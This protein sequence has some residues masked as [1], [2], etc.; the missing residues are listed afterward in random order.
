MVIEGL[1][2]KSTA[3][4]SGRRACLSGNADPR[5]GRIRVLGLWLA[6]VKKLIKV[7]RKDFLPVALITHLTTPPAIGWAAARLN[8]A[9]SAIHL[10]SGNHP[11]C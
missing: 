3:A 8:D 4:I 6:K 1:M 9:P 7:S 5:N 11:G 2:M 10:G